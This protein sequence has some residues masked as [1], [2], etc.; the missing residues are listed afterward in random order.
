MKIG[1]LPNKNNLNKLVVTISIA[2]IIII[3]LLLIWQGL[4]FTDMGYSLTCYQQIFNDP[5]CT[6]YC[7]PNWMQYIIGGLWMKI[8]NNLGLMGM[9]LGGVVITWL[10]AIFTYKIL[11]KYIEKKI[12]LIA[13]VIS[14]IYSLDYIIMVHYDNLTALFFVI[15]IFLL[16]KYIDTHKIVYL[17]TAGIIECINTLVRLPNI[18]GITF[19]L[20]V[21][22][23]NHNENKKFKKQISDIIIFFVGFTLTLALSLL[24][25][26]KM[27]YLKLYFDGVL[28]LFKI[29]SSQG[30][31]HNG[32]TLFKTFFDSN[33]NSIGYSLFICSIILIICM[34]ISKIKNKLLLFVLNI[35]ILLVIFYCFKLFYVNIIVGISYFVCT[36]YI[37]NIEETEFNFK[38]I[39]LLGFIMLLISPVGTT[40]GETIT[41][42][43]S[44][45]TI[46]IIFY[47][48]ISLYKS[49][50]VICFDVNNSKHNNKFTIKN[51]IIKLFSILFIA[52]IS[53]YVIKGTYCFTY[54]DSSNRF[55]M[56]YN[57]DNK[58]L[59][60]TFTTKERALAVND[61]LMALSKYIHKNDYLWAEGAMSTVYYATETKPY[62]SDP[63]DSSIEVPL[64]TALKRAKDERFTL[65]VIIKQNVDTGDSD[66]PHTIFKLNDHMG[67]SDEHNKII[68]NFIMQYNYR[69]VWSSDYFKI[70]ITDQKISK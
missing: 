23:A 4:D 63:W 46:P 62:V 31:V 69:L 43:T 66:W 37:A 65:P 30:T 8:F 3:P 58:Y 34:I 56:I 47:F 38:L 53:L 54:R 7:L 13:L 64:D 61:L 17:F 48:L 28:G 14:T 49:E 18:L 16:M 9:N 45:I 50:T 1:L 57:I 10:T 29:S 27:N 24:I 42:Y 20:V 52:L 40:I 19:F 6:A 68:D 12:L 60:Y 44:W 22:I 2:L 11:N 67:I 36:L 59:K 25:M 5:S 70:Y 21:I 39:N 35:A 26:K 41:V 33:C 15:T 32:N 55:K 51:I